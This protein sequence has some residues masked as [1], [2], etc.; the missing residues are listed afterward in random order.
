MLQ[1][2]H[3]AIGWVTLVLLQVTQ[4]GPDLVEELAEKSWIV[5][6]QEIGVMGVEQLL[7]DGKTHLD[8]GGGGARGRGRGRG[9]GRKGGDPGIYSKRSLVFSKYWGP[10][11]S[12]KKNL[13][14]NWVEWKVSGGEELA[15]KAGASANIGIQLIHWG[16][17][18]RVC[19][20]SNLNTSYPIPCN[21]I[22]QTL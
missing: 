20:S 21:T 13:L 18:P 2:N 22:M 17:W 14:Y 7:R 16:A 1:A 15:H 9:R 19:W 6:Q 5:F 8:E 4:R 10:Q 11:V 3:N 12:R